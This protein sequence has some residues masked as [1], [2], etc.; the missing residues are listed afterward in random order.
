MS[1][2]T[3]PVITFAMVLVGLFVGAGAISLTLKLADSFSP[4]L[5]VVS[6]TVLVGSLLFLLMPKSRDFE[7]IG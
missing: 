5:Y 6:G 1:L 2:D 4:F 3:V 7:K